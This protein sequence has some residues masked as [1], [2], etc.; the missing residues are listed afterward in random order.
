MMEA[1]MKWIKITDQRPHLGMPCLC[2]KRFDNDVNYLFLATYREYSD[3]APVWIDE[4][5]KELK[6]DSVD[7]WMDLCALDNEA[8]HEVD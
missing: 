8:S 2:K 6:D 7:L 5:N 4:N 1:R 3:G